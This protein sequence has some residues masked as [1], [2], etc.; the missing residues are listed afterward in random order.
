MNLVNHKPSSSLA[1]HIARSGNGLS[2]FSIIGRKAT[3]PIL[4]PNRIRK[5][6]HRPFISES[7][8]YIMRS[9]FIKTVVFI[10]FVNRFADRV[11]TL[12]I[13]SV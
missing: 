8:D 7:L 9:G 11:P 13:Q 6:N 3:V 2:P 4:L 5:D 10:M 12:N 1:E